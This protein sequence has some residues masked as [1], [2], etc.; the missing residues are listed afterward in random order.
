VHLGDYIYEYASGRYGN[1]R[2]YEPPTEIVSLQDYRTRHAQYKRDADLQELH[3]QHPMVAI[4]D[5]HEITNDTLGAGRRKPHHRHRRRL[6][7]RVSAGLRPTTSGCRSAWSTR[8]IRAAST[9]SFALGDLADLVML[10]ER[11]LGRSEQLTPR[12]RFRQ[13]G[14]F[15]DPARTLLGAEQESWLA[16][17]LRARAPSGSWSDRA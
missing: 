11:L 6:P 10:E 15:A 8:P 14:A 2:A 12:T 3:R 4:W 17:K 9:R 7:A 13:T 1:L 5:D 16:A